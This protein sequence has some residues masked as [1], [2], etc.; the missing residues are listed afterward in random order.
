MLVLETGFSNPS[1]N[2]SIIWKD[3]T[4]TL[5]RISVSYDAGSGSTMRFG[6]LYN[7]GYQSSDL[8]TIASTGAATFASSVTANGNVS[9]YGQLRLESSAYG[10]IVVGSRSSETDFQIYN[11]GNI[12]R[13]YNGTSDALNINTAGNVGI[14]TTATN[15]KLQVKSDTNQNL[16][17]GTQ[18][19]ELSFE[20]V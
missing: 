1:G 17:I 3:A 19:G 16:V 12:F 7:G 15:G 14:G 4:N 11:T 18:G 6:S 2:K 5:G 10:S 8:L 20:V 9:S 13:I